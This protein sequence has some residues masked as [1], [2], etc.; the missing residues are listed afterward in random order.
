M[1]MGPEALR[2]CPACGR[3]GDSEFCEHDGALM[4][5]REALAT[6]ADGMIGR[7]IRGRYRLVRT[8]GAGGMGKVY[9]ASQLGLQREVAVKVLRRFATDDPAEQRAVVLRFQREVLA[10]S[11]LQHPNTIRVYDYGTAEDGTLYLVMELLHGRTLGDALREG[12]ALTPQAVA[13]V[14][15]QVCRS[16]AEAHEQGIVHRDLKPDNVFLVQVHG[17]LEQVKVLDFG[18]AKVASPP[19]GT[20]LGTLTTSRTIVGTA[21]YMAPEQADG[22]EVGPP[23]DLY[24]LG[25][26]L[27][28]A[29]TGALPFD[30]KTSVSVMVKRSLDGPPE[31]PAH[32]N[33]QPVPPAL[34]ALVR[35]LMARTPAE[36]PASA[37][38]V[39]E[40]LEALADPAAPTFA[41]PPTDRAR[42]PARSALTLGAGVLLAAGLV[43]AGGWLRAALTPP[44]KSPPAR[45]ASTCPEPQCPSAAPC[46]TCQCP[47]PA[48]CPTPEP[49]APALTNESPPPRP[50]AP[51]ASTQA[52]VAPPRKSASALQAPRAKAARRPDE[53]PACDSAR[54]PFTTACRHASGRVLKGDEFCFPAF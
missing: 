41:G 45:L 26:I 16:L 5:P 40:A 1:V 23:A 21:A 54:C 48:A 8:L 4:I 33:G 29:L 37:L 24:A 27:F 7:V 19:E 52:Q 20:L 22:A 2:V 35:Q 9:A 39:A 3:S 50:P 15:A 31:V 53:L 30:G 13:R 38:A 49:P 10:A 34:A 11:R 14:G 51:A 44:V 43:L 46:P 32:V 6:A 28:Q 25:V 47:A 36:R 18:I 42:R 17:G 12:R